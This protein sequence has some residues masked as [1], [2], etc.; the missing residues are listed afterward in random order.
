M[1]KKRKKH[2]RRPFQN[3]KFWISFEF[4]SGRVYDQRCKNQK[5]K[6][7]KNVCLVDLSEVRAPKRECRKCKNKG[8]DEKVSLT[9]TSRKAQSGRRRPVEKLSLVKVDQ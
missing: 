9:S 7:D 3:Q 6:I 8:R 2:F 1:K 4:I 5:N